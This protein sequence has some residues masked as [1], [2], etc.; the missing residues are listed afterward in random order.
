[1]TQRQGVEYRGKVLMIMFSTKLDHI[2]HQ[3]A[4]IARGVAVERKEVPELDLERELDLGTGHYGATRV[5][6]KLA[7]SMKTVRAVVDSGL[8]KLPMQSASS[9][10]AWVEANY[11]DLIT[12]D[13][14]FAI[15]KAIIEEVTGDGAW[16][17]LRIC[18]FISW[19]MVGALGAFWFCTDSVQATFGILHRAFP[20]SWH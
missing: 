14:Y 8:S 3:A 19:F 2:R 20:A 18:A 17:R 15:D 13:R 5:D 1:M 12:F 16:P 6:S 7:Q 10:N 11:K 4:A 9:V